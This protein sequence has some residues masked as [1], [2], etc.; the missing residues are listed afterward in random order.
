MINARI[1]QQF[2]RRISR[3]VFGSRDNS[4]SV[5]DG[6]STFV[7]ADNLLRVGCFAMEKNALPSSTDTPYLN[8]EY[9]EF[10]SVRCTHAVRLTL[11]AE[12]FIAESGTSHADSFFE[13]V[14]EP[15]PVMAVAGEVLSV[16]MTEVVLDAG[17]SGKREGEE[18]REE[19]TRRPQ[20][21]NAD[22]TK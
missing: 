2:E 11:V 1:R 7:T 8:S 14:V 9:R 21:G 13:D 3:I 12:P 6:R 17:D 10:P 18:V 19:L 5:V 15:E 4:G 22:R 20:T 16:S